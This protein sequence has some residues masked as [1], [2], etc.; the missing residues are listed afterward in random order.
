M[1][2]VCVREKEKILK[3]GYE[4]YMYENE[5]IVTP[6]KNIRC[7]YEEIKLTLHPI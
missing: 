7:K 2:Y 1:N 3:I 6:R 4:N 5:N